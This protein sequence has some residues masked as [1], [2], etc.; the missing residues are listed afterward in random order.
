MVGVTGEMVGQLGTSIFSNFVE[1]NR[2]YELLLHFTL[3]QLTWTVTP[4]KPETSQS[5]VPTV[6]TISS[7]VVSYGNK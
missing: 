7:G 3:T 2:N 1:Y 6:P 4:W 5:T